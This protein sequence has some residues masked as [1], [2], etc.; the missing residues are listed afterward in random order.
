MESDHFRDPSSTVL[1]VNRKY[2]DWEV[3]DAKPRGA[4]KSYKFLRLFC[5]V[6]WYLSELDKSSQNRQTYVDHYKRSLFVYT[7]LI[8]TPIVGNAERDLLW[9]VVYDGGHGQCNLRNQFEP[10]H[11]QFIPI[12]KY[13][14]DTVEIGISETDG[15]QTVC[16]NPNSE[17]IVTLW[18]K[19]RSQK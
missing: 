9:E 18:F 7:D 15:K 1:K 19:R 8:Q 2:F 6:N 12:I 16:T 4:N 14:F 11:F 10:K 5:Y 17:R 3:A 13:K